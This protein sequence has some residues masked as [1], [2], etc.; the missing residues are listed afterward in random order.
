MRHLAEVVF[1]LTAGLSAARAEPDSVLVPKLVG[2]DVYHAHRTLKR[3]GLASSFGQVEADTATV[4][5]FCVASQAPDSGSPA[6]PG[7]TVRLGFNCPGMLRHWNPSVIPLL[8]D[9]ANT[10]GFYQVQRPPRP[11]TVVSAEYPQALKA[12]S[13]GGGADVEALVDF[14]GSVLAARVVGSSGYGAA[15]SSAC[16]AALRMV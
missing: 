13:F 12:Y 6:K 16:A 8:G 3:L 10:V 2:Q 14:D 5:L 11:T 7:D 4:P 1:V 15:D 9:F